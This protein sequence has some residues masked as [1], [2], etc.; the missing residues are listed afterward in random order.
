MSCRQEQNPF[1]P[2]ESDAFAP[3]TD[4]F[5]DP[6]FHDDLIRDLDQTIFNPN[7][8]GRTFMIGDNF[9][10]SLVCPGVLTQAPAS[11]EEVNGLYAMNVNAVFYMKK[12]DYNKF[13]QRDKDRYR[14]GGFIC[15][16]HIKYKIIKIDLDYGF[17]MMNLQYTEGML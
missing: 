13:S 1:K 4:P 10:T 6:P 9:E 5:V 16:N 14:K 2:V 15:I 3:M 8:F 7:E 17:V 12:K 11:K